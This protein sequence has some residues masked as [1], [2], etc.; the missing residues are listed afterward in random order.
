MATSRIGS[1]RAGGGFSFLLC[2]TAKGWNTRRLGLA[3]V[4]GLLSLAEI[5]TRTDFENRLNEDYV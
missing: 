5:S 2:F 4:L 1:F 3:C